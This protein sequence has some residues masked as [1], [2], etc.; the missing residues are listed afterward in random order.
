MRKCLYYTK[1][2]K[3]TNKTVLLLR[4]VDDF[5]IACEDRELASTVISDIN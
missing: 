3:G 5:A 4:Q 1:N 2:Y